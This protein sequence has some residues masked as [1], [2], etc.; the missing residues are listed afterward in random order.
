MDAETTAN[1][2]TKEAFEEL[3]AANR[4]LRTEIDEHRRAEEALREKE[5]R[6]R[7][8]AEFA[9]D[10]VFWRGADDS[11][12][13]VAPACE[14]IS[15]YAPSEFYGSP[16]LF[17][18]IIHPEDRELWE[19]HVREVR[20]ARRSV[21]MELRIVTKQGE[22]RWISHVSRPVFGEGGQFLGIRGSNSNVT[23]RK[24]SELALRR[25]EERLRD[26]FDNASDLIQSVSA[27]GRFL[28]VNRAWKETLGYAEDEMDRLTVFD[29]IAP[30]CIDHCRTMF[31]R[32]MAGE[33]MSNIETTFL[34][35]DGR[36]IVVE[37]HVN[38]RFEDGKPSA[39]R[40]IFR[41][42][43][44]KRKMEEEVR[45]TRTLESIGILAGGIAHDFNNILTAIM[46]NLALA[47]A[48]I[49]TGSESWQR[50]ANAEKAS[51][52]AQ[53]LTRQLL[54]F[55]KGGAPIRQSASIADLIEESAETA[56]RGSNVQ[57]GISVAPDLAPV[58]VDHGQIGQVI[59]N[60]VINAAQAMP[61]GGFVR[62]DA[63]NAVVPGGPGSALRGGEYVR[64]TIEDCGP[65][66]PEEH[67]GKIFDPFFTT[68]EK[69]TGLGLATSYSI[70]KRH[71][72]AITVDSTAGK[73][74]TFTVYLP[75]SARTVPAGTASG[76]PPG[77]A[78][79][80]LIMDDEEMVRDVARSFVET[81][82]FHGTA[83]ADGSAAV[84][85]YVAAMKEGTRF[86]AVLLDLTVPGS[87]GG[88]EAVAKLLEADPEATV[89]VS[90]GYSQDP[91]MAEHRK[92]GFSG[93]IAKPYRIAELGQV[94]KTAISA[95]HEEVH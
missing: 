11:L 36:R 26:F 56:L 90:S 94:L 15:G 27:E 34:A 22:T 68:K 70:V 80:V 82:G 3:R 2:E 73:G 25:S 83:V 95:D 57:S 71:D 48:G 7:T 75:A 54:T 78:G 58:D 69:G 14:Q 59:G 64:I 17:S 76:A 85:A 38:C 13:Y 47:K 81:L 63:R 24:K 65:G 84:D 60:I 49:G 62:I 42:V 12:L 52:R 31:G 53:G 86:D 5:E 61:G 88:K 91:V 93:V 41:D 45:K 74:S 40:G 21:Q 79:R 8:L 89:I 77:G 18:S 92:Y 32:V 72:G 33:E 28:Y 44:E 4:R 1:R 55:S 30:D 67:L 51:L 20:G 43:T 19:R 10:W 66:I 29:I 39:T 23:E 87:M 46:G 35:K 37:G 50:L 6:F 16:G 9:S